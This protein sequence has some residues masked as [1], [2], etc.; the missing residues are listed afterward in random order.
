[1]KRKFSV[2]ATSV[3]LIASVAVAT[4]S[5]A[6]N[7]AGGSC[8][9]A[10]ATTKIGG[11]TYVCTKNPTVK[12]AK[13]TWVW[14]QC[15]SANKDYVAAQKT[16]SDS[17]AKAT[18]ELA[19]IDED[20]AKYQATVT[21]NEAKAVAAETKAKDLQAKAAA[22]G[23]TIVDKAFKAD[24]KRV[25]TTATGEA[26]ATITAT[27]V[28]ALASQWKTTVDKVAPMIQ[29]LSADDLLIQADQFRAP[30]RT[31]ESLKAQRVRT[32]NFQTTMKNS[33]TT[34]L[35]STKSTRDQACKPGL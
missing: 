20:I 7:K 22:K 24:I 10:N 34:S 35:Q 2:L 14:N 12:N 28:I 32:V 21:I 26:K 1:M 33:A 25:M 6:A 29:W 23:I 17:L 11:D 13:L 8:T 3:A 15:I 5:Y 31:I 4:P 16:L 30:A 27:E 19:K 9:K 18:A